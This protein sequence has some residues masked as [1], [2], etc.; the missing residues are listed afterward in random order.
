MPRAKNKIYYNIN[1]SE[2]FYDIDD[3]SFYF[4]KIQYKEKFIETFKDHRLTMTQRLEYRY[5][6]KLNCNEWCDF[7]LYVITEKKG[8]RVYKGGVL[9]CRNNLILDGA[10][11]TLRS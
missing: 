10:I 11:K 8:F 9:L 5:G 2:Y 6:F 3:L 7:N 1:V 4:S